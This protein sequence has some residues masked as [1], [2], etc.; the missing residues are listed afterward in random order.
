MRLNMHIKDG[1]EIIV[2]FANDLTK[3]CKE[4]L[5]DVQKMSLHYFLIVQCFNNVAS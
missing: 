3:P 2:T 4:L 1:T 5:P